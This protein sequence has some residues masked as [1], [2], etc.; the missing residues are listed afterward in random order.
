M[1]G[2]LL[3]KLRHKS[4]FVAHAGLQWRDFDLLQPLPPRFKQFCLSLLRSWDYRHAPPCLDNCCI[5]S[6]DG[7]SQCWSQTPD[8]M[9][10]LPQPPKQSLA[11][12][13]GARLECSGAISAH[14]NLRLPGSSNSPASASQVAGTTVE[15]RFHY[16]GQAGL[17]LLTLGNLPTLASQSAEITVSFCCFLRLSLAFL[18][19]PECSVTILAHCNLCLLGSSDSPASDSQMECHPVTQAVVQWH[20]LGSLNLCLLGS[21][22]SPSSASSVAGTTGTCHHTQLIFSLVTKAGVQWCNLDSLQPLPPGSSNLLPQPP[23]KLE[24]QACATRPSQFLYF[25]IETGFHHVGQAGLEL[26]TSGLW[27]AKAGGSLKVWSSRTAWPTWQNPIS[28]K[29]QKLA[30]H[31][32]DSI[33]KTKQN[34]L[35]VVAHTFDPSTLGGQS[36]QITCSQ[37]FD[38][39]LTN[40]EKA[41]LY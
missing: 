13:L 25:L 6:R 39:S 34:R 21:S 7:V 17:E 1:F 19:R 10:R 16:V 28:T 14:C 41:H 33:S 27:E 15:M 38:T 5:F 4:R 11:L 8:I 32:Q 22:D 9:I 40:M 26:L 29:T 31:E 30:G 3:S 18:P 23:E 2:Q 37:E 35:G 20:N 12:S 24:L 36:G